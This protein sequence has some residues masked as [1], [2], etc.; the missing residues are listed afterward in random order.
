MSDRNCAYN[1]ASILIYWNFCKRINFN[2][3]CCLFCLMEET[4]EHFLIC[5]PYQDIKNDYS[6][7]S[8]QHS[9]KANLRDANRPNLTVKISHSYTCSY[10][11]YEDSCLSK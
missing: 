11:L 6:P 9:H 8:R 7:Y 2:L 3:F 4:A 1:D 10:V 5:F